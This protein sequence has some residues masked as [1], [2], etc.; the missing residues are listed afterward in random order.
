MLHG[1]D[2]SWHCSSKLL[3]DAC[4]ASASTNSMTAAKGALHSM[5]T[6][7]SEAHHTQHMEASKWL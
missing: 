3:V 6:T 7:G 4:A 2:S 1:A 5:Q